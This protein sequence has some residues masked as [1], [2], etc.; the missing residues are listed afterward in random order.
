MAHSSECTDQYAQKALDGADIVRDAMF[1]Q[2][3]N[4]LHCNPM[5]P[6]LWAFIV[7]ILLASECA[8]GPGTEPRPGQSFERGANGS[9]PDR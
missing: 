1:R 8:Y 2:L 6:R 7:A 3:W 9:V 5:K 4:R